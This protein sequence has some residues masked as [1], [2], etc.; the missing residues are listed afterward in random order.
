MSNPINIEE[1]HTVFFNL[2][3]KQFKHFKSIIW[4][5]GFWCCFFGKTWLVERYLAFKQGFWKS[6]Q[7]HIR[8]IEKQI[9]TVIF[10]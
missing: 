7:S 6:L 2:K 8:R 1:L 9:V 10:T 4:M 3:D 5:S